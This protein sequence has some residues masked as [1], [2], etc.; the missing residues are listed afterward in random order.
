VGSRAFARREVEKCYLAVLE[1]I[2]DPTEW[3]MEP[4]A[5]EYRKSARMQQD[6]D[7]YCYAFRYGV[8]FMQKSVVHID[9]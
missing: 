8:R 3:P 2:V 7:D 1:G 5:S 4:A 9:I 6:T